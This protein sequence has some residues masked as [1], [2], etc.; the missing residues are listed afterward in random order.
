MIA[1]TGAS[2]NRKFF[3][4]NKVESDEALVYKT[5]NIFSDEKQPLFFLSDVPHLI[6]TV[7]NNW[8]I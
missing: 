3:K 2:A 6:K 8:S 1:I 7:R 4:L 5:V